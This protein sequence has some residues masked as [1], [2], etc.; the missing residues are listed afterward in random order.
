MQVEL[1][2]LR[3]AG[4]MNR[5]QSGGRRPLEDT[6]NDAQADAAAGDALTQR[7]ALRRDHQRAANTTAAIWQQINQGRSR[8]RRERDQGD[9]LGL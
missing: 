3:A 7:A 5:R 8:P 9:Y 4:D 1:A 2:M 6:A